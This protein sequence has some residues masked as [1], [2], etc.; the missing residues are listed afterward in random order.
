MHLNYD[1]LINSPER[2]CGRHFCLSTI[3]STNIPLCYAT[4]ETIILLSIDPFETFTIIIFA[5]LSQYSYK[6]SSLSFA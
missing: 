3:F 2:N 1:I 6:S 5:N 4:F